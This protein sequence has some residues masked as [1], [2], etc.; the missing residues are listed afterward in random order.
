MIVDIHAH[1]HPDAYCEALSKLY[2]RTVTNFRPH[3]DTDNPEHIKTRLQQMDD[4]GVRLQV[5]SP[6][7]GHAPYGEDEGLAV[8]AARMI[9]DMNAAV[10]AQHPDKFKSFVSLPLPHIEASVAELKRS[11]EP[12]FN[13]VRANFWNSFLSM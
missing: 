13:R 5:L 4:A 10:V 9:N 2:G 11:W 7:A 12:C 8:E 3:P 6:A 1:Y